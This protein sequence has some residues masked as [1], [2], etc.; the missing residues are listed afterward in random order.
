MSRK[1]HYPLSLVLAAL[2]KLCEIRVLIKPNLGSTCNLVC[3]QEE[4]MLKTAVSMATEKYK[5]LLRLHGLANAPLSDITS[6]LRNAS[7]TYQLS[8][9]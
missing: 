3:I 8:P 2:E 4:D 5:D 9:S 1:L 7:F 6:R